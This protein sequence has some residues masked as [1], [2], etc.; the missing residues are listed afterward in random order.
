VAAFSNNARANLV[1]YVQQQ[2]EA[3]GVVPDEKTLVL[4]RFKDEL[5]DWRVVLH[6]PYGRGVNA[7][8]ALA[9]GARIAEQ[10]GIDAQ[11]VAGDDGIVLRLPEGESPPGTELV[12]FDP[13]DIEQ[14]VAEQ[15]GNSALFASRFRECAARALLLPRRNPGKRA[16]LWQQRQRAAQLLD[17]ARKYPSFPVILETVR[18]CLQDVYDLP[19]LKDLCR[20]LQERRVQVAEV[21]VEQPSPFSSSLLFNYTGAFLYEGDSPLAEKRAKGPVKKR[22]T[23]KKTAKTTKTAKTARISGPLHPHTASGTSIQRVPAVLRSYAG[24]AVGPHQSGWSTRSDH[25]PAV[26]PST[27]EVPCSSVFC[28]PICAPTGPCWLGSSS[29]R[30]CR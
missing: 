20:E 10:T 30:S 3:T 26:A 21:T 19:A 2:Q 29:C 6:S 11:P 25:G 27:S 13:G 14:I 24:P 23:R 1:N 28:A 18:E 15:V 7:A 8:W 9:I 22:T 5:G 16:P 12:M 17:I 4:E